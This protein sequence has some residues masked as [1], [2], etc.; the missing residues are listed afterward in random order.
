MENSTIEIYLNKPMQIG[1]FQVKLK[2]NKELASPF[3]L[4]LFKQK[5]N[6]DTNKGVDNKIDFFK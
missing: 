1:C 5:K 4:R 2:F 6:F 3:E